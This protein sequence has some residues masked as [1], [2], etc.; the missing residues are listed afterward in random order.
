V[1][2]AVTAVVLLGGVG[3][4]GWLYTHRQARSAG[5]DRQVGNVRPIARTS[6]SP[7]PS[8][9]EPTSPSPSSPSPSNSLPGEVVIAPGVTDPA[10][11]QIAE[12]LGQ[13]F[14]AINTHDYTAYVALES[15]QQRQ[16]LTATQFQNGY[17]ST[18]DTGETLQ[19]VSVDGNGDY[20]AQVTFSSAQDPAQSATGTGCTKW[21]ISLY[22]IPNG[23]GFLI[24]EP[25]SSYHAAYTTC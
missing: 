20:V 4:G 9:P 5:A 3:A 23:G 10:A 25:P 7:S 24:D 15:Q 18:A 13:Y 22:L 16:G 2:G 11:P 14:D 1:V 21:D 12:F 8:S 6:T 17:G 19:G